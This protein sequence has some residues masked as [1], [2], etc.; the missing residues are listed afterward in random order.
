MFNT[1]ENRTCLPSVLGQTLQ[2]LSPHRT[3]RETCRGM[4]G[5][6]LSPGSLPGWGSSGSRAG[7][8]RGREPGEM[9]RSEQGTSVS[10]K[11][12][13]RKYSVVSM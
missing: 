13:T 2:H 8:G 10:S 5:E 6:M 12:V 7:V 1:V 9:G 4:M 3:M 11:S